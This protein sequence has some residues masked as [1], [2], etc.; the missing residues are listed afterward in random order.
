[1]GAGDP[2]EKPS[3]TEAAFFRPPAEVS[4]K[5]RFSLHGGLICGRG[6]V[7]CSTRRAA[8]T[9]AGEADI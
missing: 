7:H 6:V 3:L 2:V 9:L 4:A 5:K 1:M 8:D